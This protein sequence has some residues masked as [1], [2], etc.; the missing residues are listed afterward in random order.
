MSQS[1]EDEIT[2]VCGQEKNNLIWDY[3]NSIKTFE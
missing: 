3:Q 1:A 2:D